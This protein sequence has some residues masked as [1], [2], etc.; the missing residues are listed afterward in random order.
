MK[1]LFTWA[2]LVFLVLCTSCGGGQKKADKETEVLIET[3]V[4]NIKVKL[5]ND[6]PRHRDNFLRLV[7]AGAYNNCLF[8]RIVK[9]FMIQT[10]DPKIRVG[11]P[12]A[13]ADTMKY[14]YTI[15]AEI[16]FPRHFNKQG[17]L[18]AARMGDDVNPQKASSGTQ[19]Y[20]VTGRI[21]APE[22]LSDLGNTL[23]QARIDTLYAQYRRAN[24]ARIAALTKAG[25]K[26]AL[27]SFK[28]SLEHAAETLVAQNPPVTL[29]PSQIEAYSTV[30]G[31]PH[32][33]AEYTVFGEVVEGMKVVQAISR[34]KVQGERPLET[35]F[36]K[37]VSIVK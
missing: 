18:G 21:Y 22:E 20:I 23:Y 3:S 7:K 26:A 10:G 24:S 1:R 9:D 14:H 30:G 11:Q 35:I 5:Y 25:K 17:A 33:D 6:T 12:L 19:F 15:P 29:G 8:H 37:R 16:L 28:D 32:L 36:I 2:A 34:A 4:G 31:A 13:P 27:E